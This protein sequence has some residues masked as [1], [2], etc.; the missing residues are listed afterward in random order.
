MSSDLYIAWW[1]LENLF[2]IERSPTRPEW[3][4]SRLKSELK[5]WNASVLNEKLQQLAKVIS[6]MNNG[7]G[8]DLLGVC[9]VESE[10]VLAKLIDKLSATGRDYGIVHA[11]TSDNR[12][13]DV[14]F[15][16][17]KNKMKTDPSVI[18][19]RVILKRNATRDLLQATFTTNEGNTF[20]VIGNHWPSRRGGEE[21]S[22]PY[23][24]MAG[25]TLSYWVERIKEKLGEVPV[26]VMGDFNDEPFNHS[27]INYALSC[28]SIRKVK[29][30]RAK[31]PYLYN[32]M[33]HL[34][35]EDI[36]THSY[37]KTWGMLDQL[38]VNRAGLEKTGIYCTPKAAEIFTLPEMIKRDTPV[39]FG[40]PSTKGGHNPQGYSD[41]LPVVL[42]L[43]QSD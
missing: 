19:N 32:L 14:A 35:G 39:R 41:H 5:G 25:E 42:G 27:L 13:I 9:E 36:A 34:M 1:N 2:D 37:D 21:A 24:M 11:D 33:T 30:K 7:Q 43:K 22:A 29:S 23:R 31:N 10:S 16:Y 40:R 20:I 18:F 15:I 17:D 4:K 38:L 28:K 26:F 12:G 8:P 6:S 3:L